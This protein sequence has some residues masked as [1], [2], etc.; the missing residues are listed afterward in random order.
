MSTVLQYTDYKK[1]IYD[2]V[3]GEIPYHY[4]QVQL[5][6]AM[7]CQ[8]A[9]LSQVIKDKSE[10][11]EEQ[12]IRLCHFLD[13][14]RLET[15]YFLTILRI[16][17]A[18]TEDLKKYLQVSRDAL[19]KSYHEIS[20]RVDISKNLETHEGMIFYCSS[21]IPPMIHLLT[22]MEKYQTIEAL[23]K[24]LNL[25]ESVIQKYLQSL[26]K[27]NFLTF[28]NKRWIFKGDSFHIPKGS[29]LDLSFMTNHRL[30]TLSHL[31]MRSEG[32]VHYSKMVTLDQATAAKIRQTIIDFLDQNN[33]YVEAAPEEDVYSFSIDFFK[34]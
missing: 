13:F 14:K 3:K 2:M 24:R 4:S 6:K 33:R 7:N 19:V 30:Y 31:P 21:W 32:D 5:A 29:A 16:S 26:L 27:Y 18:G 28:E 11:T 10:L 25:D 12:G 20:E 34:A 9:Y 8:A 1:F 17:R 15:E 22:S 23:A